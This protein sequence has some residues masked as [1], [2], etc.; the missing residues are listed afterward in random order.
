MTVWWL[1]SPSISTSVP[2]R[3]LSLNLLIRIDFF[4]CDILGFIKNL[5]LEFHP[6]SVP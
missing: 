1:T 3:H 2:I 5:P 6:N 4:L